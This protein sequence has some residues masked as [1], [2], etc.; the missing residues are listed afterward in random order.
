MAMTSLLASFQTTSDLLSYFFCQAT[1]SR[2]NNATAVL[3]GLIYLL[4]DQHPSLIPHV[5]KKYD[6]TAEIFTNILRDLNLNST[7][8]IIDALDGCVADL[9]KLLEFVA[10]QSLATSRVKWIVS[11]LNWPD[12]EERLEWAGPQ[13]IHQAEGVPACAEDEVQRQNARRC[14]R[15]SGVERERYLPLVALVCQNLEE[16]PRRNV[17]KRS[18][19][20]PPGLDS[21]YE[22]MM[23]QISD[24]DDADL[25]KQLED[26]ADNQKSIQEII[27]LC[28]SF[29][30]VR[31]DTVYFLHQSAKD[32]LLAEAL[33]TAFPSGKEDAHF[34]VVSRS[35]Q[36]TRLGHCVET[37]SC[38]SCIYWIDHLYDSTPS[39]LAS[40]VYE[41]EVLLT[42]F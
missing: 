32:F 34:A 6:H 23:H 17:L 7:Y 11:S 24:L 3:R 2:I 28:G 30:A 27:S 33:D 40:Y 20:F 29:L 15:A 39:T 38:Y 4:V 9:P 22:R 16:I 21:L 18:N 10:Q 25:C 41:T 42:C 1:D 8:L 12:I 5:R 14:A 19:A 37:S 13:H 31:E 26:L 35:L 36:A